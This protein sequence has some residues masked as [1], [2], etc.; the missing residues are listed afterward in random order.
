MK[1]LGHFLCGA[2]VLAISGACSYSVPAR[3]A[4][5]PLDP[6]SV[7]EIRTATH[8]MKTDER[9]ASAVFPLITL[10]APPKSEVVAWKSGQKITRRA[11][12]VAMASAAV[13]EVVV[14]LAA[15]R[16]ISVVE[17]K[18]V[19]API[20][21]TEQS[22]SVKVVL[23][24]PDFRE[25]LKKRGV[26]DLTK[27]FCAPFAAGYYGIREHEGKRLLKVGCFDIRMSTNNLFGWP[28]ERL[29]ALVDLRERKVM[30]VVDYGVV[31]ID[32]GEH[33]FTEAAIGGMREH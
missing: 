15:A 28:I 8:V 1:P 26:T 12:A 13:F 10:E 11:R 29:Y 25:G 18:G 30:R 22:E 31:P 2:F 9:L 33:N 14:D 20:T 21:L 27:V 24:H 32:Q 17:R 16:L 5:H 4:E 7:E 3:M 19:E 23:E 6:L